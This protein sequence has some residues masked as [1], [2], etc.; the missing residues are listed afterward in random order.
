MVRTEKSIETRGVRLI[1]IAAIVLSAA[2]AGCWTQ[3]IGRAGQAGGGHPDGGT[4]T[5]FRVVPSDGQL[6]LVFVID[7]SGGAPAQQ[8][9][10]MQLPAL[11]QTLQG[12]PGG[13]PDLHVGVVS[14]DLGAGPNAPAGCTSS[15]DAGQFQSAPRGSCAATTL[16][17]SA[18]FV[19]NST[20]A[21]NFTD[22]IE[23]VLQCILPL[24]TGGCGFAQPLAAL[25]RALGAEGGHPPQANAGFLRANAGLAI[26][27]LSAVDDCSMTS[28]SDLLNSDPSATGLSDPLGPLTHYRCNRY[29]HLCSGGGMMLAPPPLGPAPAGPDDHGMEQLTDCVANDQPDAPLRRVSD[30][31]AAIRTLK[32]RPDEQ[33]AVA[34]IVGPWAPYAVRWTPAGAAN[35]QSPDELWPSVMQ[36]CGAAGDPAVNPNSMAWSTDGSSGEPAVRIAEF[37]RSFA[38]SQLGSICDPSYRSAMSAL[39]AQLAEVAR[40]VTCGPT[41]VKDE[42]GQEPPC[43]VLASYYDQD[44]LPA[45]TPIPNCA[46]TGNQ[47]PCW[48]AGP[49]GSSSCLAGSRPFEV[50]APRE[51]ANLPGLIYDV[52]CPICDTNSAVAGCP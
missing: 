34:A 47:L 41:S 37:V 9:L 31:A 13:L 21:T 3:Q 29:G 20:G 43:T 38:R 46:T 35:P 48:T 44:K 1:P 2:L 23:A 7:D 10:A 30:I 8:K 15:G 49:A 19:S 32:P 51:F 11:I 28:G 25:E 33:I 18:A 40:G 17:S 50:D 27:I 12:L 22:P 6:D 14:S 42:G 24:G 26:V 52:S 5:S 39:A 4:T 36:S 16:S 45:T